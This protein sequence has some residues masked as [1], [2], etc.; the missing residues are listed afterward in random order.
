MNCLRKSITIAVP[1]LA[2]VAAVAFALRGEA[3]RPDATLSPRE[4]LVV[5]AGTERATTHRG[6]SQAT[7]SDGFSAM[8]GA[9]YEYR[10]DAQWR[11]TMRQSR[12]ASDSLLDWNVEDDVPTRLSVRVRGRMEVRV[13]D[14]SE[15]EYLV[16]FE[17]LGATG[18]QRSGLDRTQ[19]D[20]R[21]LTGAGW[22]RMTQTGR[23]LGFAFDP[24]VPSRAR[25]LQAS[26][27]AMT[28]QFVSGDGPEWIESGLYDGTGVYS[29]RFGWS[30]ARL[31]RDEGRDVLRRIVVSYAAGTQDAKRNRAEASFADGWLS[32]VRVRGDRVGSLAAL[33]ARVRTDVTLERIAATTIAVDPN[34]APAADAF[35]FPTH[36]ASE[37]DDAL[38]R[39]V[40]EFRGDPTVRF[41]EI[42][43]ELDGLADDD[44]LDTQAGYE[45]WRALAELVEQRPDEVLPLI[46][47]R[48]RSSETAPG[49]MHWLVS[50]L[51]RA[52]GHGS[53]ESVDALGSLI[54]DGA[55]PEDVRLAALI[56]GHQVGVQASPALIDAITDLLLE[57]DR[58][59]PD[60]PLPNAAS[61]LVGTLAETGALP[62]EPAL[63]ELIRDDAFGR[64]DPGTY[65]EA[66][67]NSGRPGLADEIVPY[68][69]HDDVEVVAA[70]IEAL[71]SFPQSAEATAAL[72]EIAITADAPNLRA[73]ALGSLGEFAS[74]GSREA[75]EVLALAAEADADPANQRLARQTLSDLAESGE[76]S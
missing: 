27:F 14:A 51:G 68:L 26:L 56:A 8:P 6:N 22:A 40:P 32:Q 4:A 33:S 28:H 35:G 63:F 60:S 13:L 29:A 74:Q 5:S 64:G 31:L 25:E 45:V 12:S 54:G 52:G 49:S 75:A 42:T 72:A 18:T 50:A 70:S 57:G 43:A 47:A 46:D 7:A 20:P 30:P 3:P 34:E 76:D 73:Q 48:I 61:L 38:D 19:V 36:D 10:L 41:R 24:Q 58:L 23:V 17:L 67:V 1:T 71:A 2:V 9:R 69:T 59:S 16:R 44:T 37:A 53:S 62:F 65:F 55:L 21:L 15:E 39:D 11:T 66:L